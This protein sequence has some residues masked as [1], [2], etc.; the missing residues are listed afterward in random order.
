M[1]TRRALYITP[2][3]RSYR[4]VAAVTDSKVDTLKSGCI[5][6]SRTLY[7]TEWNISTYTQASLYISRA[8]LNRTCPSYGWFKKGYGF[9][10]W[11]SNLSGT[12]HRSTNTEL[13]SHPL[14]PVS[15][16]PYGKLQKGWTVSVPRM[17][18]GNSDFIRWCRYLPKELLHRPAY[19]NIEKQGEGSTKQ[20]KENDK[21]N[22][23]IT[24]N[25]LQQLWRR[26]WMHTTRTVLPWFMWAPLQG[27]L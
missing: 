23:A 21:H 24:G 8:G 4:R 15:G 5:L 20:N 9:S 6:P 25:I 1:T 3:R 17:L 13:S 16:W 18:T 10:R 2:P 11:V 12:S 26:R 7:C 22:W 27:M 19:G 14:L